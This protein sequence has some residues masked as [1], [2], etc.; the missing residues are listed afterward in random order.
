MLDAGCSWSAPPLCIS[1][2]SLVLLLAACSTT[3]KDPD[4]HY[5]PAG[6][7]VSNT[8]YRALRDLRRKVFFGRTGPGSWLRVVSVQRAS[9]LK[10]IEDGSRDHVVVVVK[11]ARVFTFGRGA[12]DEDQMELVFLEQDAD[13]SHFYFKV[14][15][16]WPDR[17]EEGEVSARYREFWEPGAGKAATQPTSKPTTQPTTPR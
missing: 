15:G 1:A 2:L 5:E 11:K 14:M 9:R 17:V 4:L 10:I 8:A 16:A 12:P 7:G 6:P 13:A 3:P